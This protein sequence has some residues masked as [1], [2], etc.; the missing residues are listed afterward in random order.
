MAT[1]SEKHPPGDPDTLEL[2]SEKDTGTDHVEDPKAQL[3]SPSDLTESEKNKIMCATDSNCL[4]IVCVECPNNEC[5]RRID[6]RLLPIL[7][8]M[9]SISLIDRTNLGLALVAGMQEDLDLAVGDRYTIIVMLFFI[10]Y[11]L[12]LA[13]MSSL[14]I[15]VS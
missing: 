13:V 10:A 5:S 2:G 6:L 4:P 14:V 3:H 15:Q 9:Y 1:T 12:V 8:V 11:M 7:G